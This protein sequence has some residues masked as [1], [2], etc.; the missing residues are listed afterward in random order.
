MT[1]LVGMELP[2]GSLAVKEFALFQSVLHTDGAQHNVLK[3][4]KAETSLSE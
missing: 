1:A 4:V 2:K 3:I